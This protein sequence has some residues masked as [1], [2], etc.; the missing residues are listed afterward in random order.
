MR[1]VDTQKLPAH[2]SKVPAEM[3]DTVGLRIYLATM[4]PNPGPRY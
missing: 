2:F 4:E 1:V 3:I